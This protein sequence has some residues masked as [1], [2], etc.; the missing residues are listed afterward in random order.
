MMVRGKQPAKN[1]PSLRES[2]TEY[3][4]DTV[5]TAKVKAKLIADSHLSVLNIQVETQDGV[6][7]LK[8]I[9]SQPMQI[10]LAEKLALSVKNV[11]KVNNLLQ[12][13]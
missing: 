12:I 13:K 9:V 8:G 11:K 5:I 6:V 3:A 1:S 2:I 7:S 10:N 4:A